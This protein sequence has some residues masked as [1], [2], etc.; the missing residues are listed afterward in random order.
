ML[1][2]CNVRR[3]TLGDRVFPVA[4]ALSPSYVTMLVKQRGDHKRHGLA[5]YLFYVFQ[6]ITF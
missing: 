5:Q 2:L 6:I 4:S 3:S 1:A